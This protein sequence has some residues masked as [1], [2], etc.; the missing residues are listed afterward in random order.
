M[1]FV[2]GIGGIFGSGP[3]SETNREVLE[4]G[5]YDDHAAMEPEVPGIDRL[6]PLG[7]IFQATAVTQ[8][9]GPIDSTTDASECAHLSFTAPLKVP[10]IVYILFLLLADA[11]SR[12]L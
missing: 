7:S 1:C 4:S 10:W 3:Y 5:I 6:W 11:I 9:C 12:D 8:A 2:T